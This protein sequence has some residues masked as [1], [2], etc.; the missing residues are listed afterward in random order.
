MYFPSP[1]TNYFLSPSIN[2][3]PS[4]STDYF[5]PLLLTT[6]P[7]PCRREG[8]SDLS[9]SQE[10]VERIAHDV[11]EKL[12]NLHQDITPKYKNKYRSLVFNL[13]DTK[14]QVCVCV[15]VSPIHVCL[16]SASECTCIC[17]SICLHE[18]LWAGDVQQI[19]L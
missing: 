6:S 16:L 14:N 10:E 18:C 12:F 4:P 8:A 5:P 3:F 1:S 2:Y 13:K 19:Q 15:C 9:I 17:M 11:E 7:P